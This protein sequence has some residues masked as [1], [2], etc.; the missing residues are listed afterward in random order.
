MVVGATPYSGQAKLTKFETAAKKNPK[1]A[2]AQIQA[3]VAAHVNNND[4]LAISYYEKAI[5]DDPKNGIAYNNIGNIYLRDKN[6]PKKALPYYLKATEV[7]PS[8]GYGWWNLGMTYGQL[9]QTAQEKKILTEGL[10]KVKKTD[11]AYQGMQ[12]TLKG[13]K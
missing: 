12:T 2:S 9:G 10:S 11:P 13:L 3:G 6:Q 8:Y 7:E 5:A 4:K 1:S